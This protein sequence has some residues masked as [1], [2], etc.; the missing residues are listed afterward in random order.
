MGAKHITT[1]SKGLISFG[2]FNVLLYAKVTSFFS[3]KS[4]AILL[5]NSI[6]KPDGDPYFSYP[7]LHIVHSQ[8]SLLSSCETNQNV[9]SGLD[10]ISCRSRPATTFGKDGLLMHNWRLTRFPCRSE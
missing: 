9:A 4:F 7:F 3:G 8:K 2:G 1:L 6:S 10:L 5:M